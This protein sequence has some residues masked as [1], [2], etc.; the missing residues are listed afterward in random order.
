MPIKLPTF[1]LTAL[2]AVSVLAA[3][4]IDPIATLNGV[5]ITEH[6]LDHAIAQLG[7]EP[8]TDRSRALERL[9]TQLLLVAE[10]RRE[11]LDQDPA[12]VA[13]IR[14]QSNIILVG[15]YLASQRPHV[16]KPSA[17]AIKT[18]YDEHPELFS[19]RAIYKLQ[20]VNIRA[21]ASQ[22]PAVR[23]HYEKIKTLADMTSWLKGRDIR[24]SSNAV[25]KAA[26]ELPADLLGP[27]SQ[28]VAGQVINVTTDQGMAVVQLTGKR[29]E[30]QSL[31]DAQPQIERFLL[32]QAL[33]AYI[34][35]KASTLRR[36]ADVKYYPPYAESN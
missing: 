36:A 34:Q 33:G 24:F 30:P 14:A 2:T 28:L 4:A 20:E 3:P 22:L 35:E 29:A 25:V 23:E 7:E 15:A 9:I 17:T 5:A 27:V 31:A 21:T 1:F 6:D 12:V 18:Y 10:A 26:E 16:A 11:R 13:A 8:K 32:N 19:K